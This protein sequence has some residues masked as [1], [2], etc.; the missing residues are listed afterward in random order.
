MHEFAIAVSDFF[1]LIS[2]TY[3]FGVIPLDTTMHVVVGFIVTFTGLKMGFRFGRV[4]V[5]LLVLETIK[6]IHAAFTI[7]HSILHGLKEFFA[8]F[9]Y[10]A[11]VY[12]VRKLKLKYPPKKRPS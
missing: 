6:A 2:K 10:P 4:F 5:F 11:W 12:T 7:D 9:T 8:T 3:I 1:G